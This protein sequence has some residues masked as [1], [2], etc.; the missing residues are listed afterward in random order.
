MFVEIC[1]ESPS[2]YLQTRRAHIEFPKL[3]FESH[4]NKL[5]IEQMYIEHAGHVLSLLDTKLNLRVTRSS[6]GSLM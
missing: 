6:L 3:H 1:L 5:E 2:N 4:K